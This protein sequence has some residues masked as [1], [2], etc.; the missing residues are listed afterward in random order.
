MDE[1]AK[2]D[3]S[4]RDVKKAK[5]GTNFVVAAPS[6]EGYAG[7]QPCCAKCRTHHH[8]KANCS[9]CFNCQR[10]SHFVRDCHSPAILVAPVNVVDA[11]PNQRACY[12]CCDP[13]HLKIVCPKLNQES[14]QSRN[15]LA[16]GWCR[17]DRGG[18]NQVRGQAYN[19][20]MNVAEV[21]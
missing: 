9:V 13:N 4:R 7:S 2:V 19:A 5:G 20:S 17:N 15:Q 6:R 3:G 1:P 18:G 12:E 16:L 14:G 21:A 11:R 10:L 8:E